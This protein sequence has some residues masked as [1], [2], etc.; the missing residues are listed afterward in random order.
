MFDPDLLLLVL[1][2]WVKLELLVRAEVEQLQEVKT[3]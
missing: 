1:E 2:L 3:G